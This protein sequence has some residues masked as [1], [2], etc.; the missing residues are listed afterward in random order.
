[1]RHVAPIATLFAAALLSSPVSARAQNTL[2]EA[3]R[4]AGWYLL[5]D[6]KSLDGWRVSDQPGSYRIANGQLTVRLLE[7]DANGD[8]ITSWRAADGE[9][10]F[11]GPSGYLYYVGRVLNHNFKN[12]EL[13]TDVK[14]WPA[15]N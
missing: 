11:K 7:W 15:S 13:K 9:I 8:P 2:T 3:E 12:F 14:A 4:A 1:M 5:F 6:G 10:V